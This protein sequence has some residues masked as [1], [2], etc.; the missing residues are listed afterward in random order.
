MEVD[1]ELAPVTLDRLDRVCQIQDVHLDDVLALREEVPCYD[2]TGAAVLDVIA[3]GHDLGPLDAERVA[4]EAGRLWFGLVEQHLII[5][6]GRARH[7]AER[8]AVWEIMKERGGG[9]SMGRMLTRFDPGA[10][11]KLWAEMELMDSLTYLLLRSVDELSEN[12]DDYL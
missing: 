1:L 4:A 2:G 11:H 9:G 10:H 5:A 7:Y 8:C 12:L 6:S 3:P